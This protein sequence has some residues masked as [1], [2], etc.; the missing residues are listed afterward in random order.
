MPMSWHI[1]VGDGQRE[2]ERS[3]LSTEMYGREIDLVTR[4]LTTYDRYSDRC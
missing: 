4:R 2:A 1:D 3:Y